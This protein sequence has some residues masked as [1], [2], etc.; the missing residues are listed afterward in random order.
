MSIGNDNITA[1]LK[2]L[3][4]KQGHWSQRRS[5]LGI[6]ECFNRSEII[7]L[8]RSLVACELIDCSSPLWYETRQKD[9]IITGT[10]LGG[11]AQDSMFRKSNSLMDEIG[12]P[13]K[14]RSWNDFQ[15]VQMAI[16]NFL[17][18]DKVIILSENVRNN[19]N[20]LRYLLNK[21]V[22]PALTLRG[23][24]RSLVVLFK[25]GKT[26][27]VDYCRHVFNFFKNPAYQNQAGYNEIYW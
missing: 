16:S 13:V 6:D 22:S 2:G 21:I 24:D 14:H 23:N 12:M 18:Y 11:V 17:I 25:K 3:P 10:F 26:N 4:N 9:G 20:G 27:I 7:Q 1:F 19:A 8:G 5:F 15:V